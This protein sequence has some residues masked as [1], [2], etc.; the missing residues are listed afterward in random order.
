[1]GY[2]QEEW[3]DIFGDNLRDVLK[4]TGYTQTDLAKAT[5]IKR[6][7]INQY[8]KKKR[9]PEIPVL[10][11]M[12]AELDISIHELAFFGERIDDDEENQ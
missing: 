2:T 4:E 6:E 3:T 7:S 12:S 1:M 11:E 9:V 10:I 8:I 5:Q